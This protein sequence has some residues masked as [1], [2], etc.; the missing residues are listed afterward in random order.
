MLKGNILYVSICVTGVS[1]KCK[2][3][4]LGQT[5]KHTKEQKN[6]QGA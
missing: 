1:E 5:R 6:K 3:I 2:K 4:Q